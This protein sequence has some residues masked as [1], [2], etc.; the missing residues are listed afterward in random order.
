TGTV[1]LTWHPLTDALYSGPVQSQQGEDV[2]VLY[3]HNLGDIP[4]NTA[5]LSVKNSCSENEVGTM[6]SDENTCGAIRIQYGLKDEFGNS[7]S[8][9]LEENTIDSTTEPEIVYLNQQ[10][11][12]ISKPGGSSSP[13][14]NPGT[15]GR[16]PG[17]PPV[18]VPPPV[19]RPA[20]TRP[21]P[22]KPNPAPSG[23]GSSGSGTRPSG[24]T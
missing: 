14:N 15:Y 9:C 4:E 20:P 12:A 16:H 22:T 1:I 11:P 6:I 5:A 17:T 19:Y 10:K 8:P 23:S 24:E 3:A 13:R 18:Y 2:L 7:A 21:A